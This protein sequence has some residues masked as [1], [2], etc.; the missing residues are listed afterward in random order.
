MKP[1]GSGQ[2]RDCMRTEVT[3]VDGK[4]DVL[5]ALKIM[6]KVRATCLIVKRRDENDETGMLLFS[7]I[8]KEVIAKKPCPGTGERLRDHVKTYLIGATGYGNSLLCAPV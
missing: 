8:A 4:L 1:S 7:D 5:S 2:V 6:K 3:K